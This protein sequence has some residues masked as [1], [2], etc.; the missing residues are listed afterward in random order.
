MQ[1]SHTRELKWEQRCLMTVH[2]YVLYLARRWSRQ[3]CEWC[4]S[5]CPLNTCTTQRPRKWRFVWPTTQLQF[6]WFLMSAKHT[7]VLW[8]RRTCTTTLI[9]QIYHWIKVPHFRQSDQRHF[10]SKLPWSLARRERPYHSS[11]SRWPGSVATTAG[12]AACRWG[13]CKPTWRC[14]PPPPSGSAACP[15]RWVDAEDEL[16]TE[17]HQN[18]MLRSCN[19]STEAK[20]IPVLHSM[21]WLMWAIVQNSMQSYHFKF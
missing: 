18:S 10:L 3:R 1:R 13:W 15:E 21:H 11:R 19:F 4:P 17:K 14:L 5:S 7:V 9:M 20:L 16:T 12:A 8:K 2:M 6:C